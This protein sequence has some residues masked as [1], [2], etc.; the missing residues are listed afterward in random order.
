MCYEYNVFALHLFL[1]IMKTKHYIIILLIF[2]FLYKKVFSAFYFTEIMPNVD[3]ETIDEY[4]Q[5][6][7]D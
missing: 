7:Y 2:I 1:K 3:Q 5:I 6:T 4:V